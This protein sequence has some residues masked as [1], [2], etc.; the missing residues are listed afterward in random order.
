ML[1]LTFTPARVHRH[2]MLVYRRYGHIWVDRPTELTR[3]FKKVWGLHAHYTRLRISSILYAIAYSLSLIRDKLGLYPVGYKSPKKD[4]NR[5]RSGITV[6]K[7]TLT[8]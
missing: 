5:T 6:S 2:G 4:S 7:R 8:E 3:N 1:L